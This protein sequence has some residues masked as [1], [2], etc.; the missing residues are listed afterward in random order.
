MTR[1]QCQ[2]QQRCSWLTCIAALPKR[3]ANK[4]NGNIK[5]NKKAFTMITLLQ[6]MTVAFL[7]YSSSVIYCCMWIIQPKG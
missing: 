1:H 4:I 5:N 7:M 3:R 2:G 6:I